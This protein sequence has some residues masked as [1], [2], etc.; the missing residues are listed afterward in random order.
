M[1]TFKV[2]QWKV[3][4]VKD[5]K[6]ASHNPQSRTT[7][8]AIKGLIDSMAK[9]SILVPIMVDANSKVIDGHRRLA[10]A[11]ELG[12]DTISAVECPEGMD[13]DVCFAAINSCLRKMNGN[14]SLSVWLQNAAAINGTLSKTFAQMKE[15]LGIV[16]V[17]ELCS[18]G[19]TAR[20]FNCVMRV[21]RYIHG[22]ISEQDICRWLMNIAKMRLVEQYI[23]SRSSSK[24]LET[25]IKENRPLV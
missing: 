2:P 11:K 10:A 19:F 23:T 6:T 21:H 24:K 14:E 5:I 22:N 16:M 1:N 13:P 8:T 17:R 3:L 20:L 15:K 7:K 4:R 18:K 25:M 12:W 9:H